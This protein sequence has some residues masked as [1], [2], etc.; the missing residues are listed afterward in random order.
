MNNVIQTVGAYAGLLALIATVVLS[1]LVFSLARDLR[2]LRE[3]AGG[4]PERD[5]EVRELSEIVAEERSQELRVLA[6]RE[7]RRNIRTGYAEGSFWQRLGRPGRIMMIAAAVL[8]VGAAAAWAGKT[9]IGGGD[10]SGTT[11]AGKS[12]PAKQKKSDSGGSDALKPS[13]IKVG[14][15]NGTGGAESGLAAE[16]AG[17]LEDE[18]Y[19]LGAVTDAPET[20]TESIVMYLKGHESEAKKVGKSIGI[21]QTG[22]MTSDVAALTPGADVTAVLGTDHSALPTG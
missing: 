4:A 11:V 10:D 15:L 2:R 5:A 8:I 18:G 22:L 16:Y 17:K 19:S 9:L 14:V 3:W 1:L 21:D 12:A 20:F 7:E 13:Q 6:E